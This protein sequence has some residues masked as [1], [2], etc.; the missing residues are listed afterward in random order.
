MF[1]I[2]E[3]D[4]KTLGDQ[5]LPMPL[6]HLRTRDPLLDSDG[7]SVTI[8][9]HGRQSDIFRDVMKQIQEAGAAYRLREGTNPP[10]EYSE[11]EDVKLLIACT[12]DWSFTDLAGEP[13][14]CTPGNIRRFWNDGRFRSIRTA[15]LT[16]IMNDANF[17]AEP[18]RVSG[19]TRGTNS[20]S[21]VLSLPVA[22]SSTLSEVTG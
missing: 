17:L 18:K 15:A 5:G 21:A 7:K 13:F 19:D 4:T 12:K 3:L 2:I 14:P 9:L 6:L 22:R 11:Q 10:A 20:S 8:T 1:D 16:F